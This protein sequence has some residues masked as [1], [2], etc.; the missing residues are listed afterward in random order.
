MFLHKATRARMERV[1]LYYEA[2]E[3]MWPGTFSG[4]P[5]SKQKSR[6][7]KP[8]CRQKLGNRQN[9]LTQAAAGR[10]AKWVRAAGKMRNAACKPADACSAMRQGKHVQIGAPPPL[11]CTRAP[12]GPRLSCKR[13]AHCSVPTFHPRLSP[14]LPLSNPTLPRCHMSDR[15]AAEREHFK[16]HGPPI[17]LPAARQGRDG[18][19]HWPPIGY[20]SSRRTRLALTLQTGL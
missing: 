9:K 15:G 1:R 13:G 4:L 17:C 11:L 16:A 18:R 5:R 3:R 10:G 6:A 20:G 19:G 8:A 2:A 7:G 14:C 12:A